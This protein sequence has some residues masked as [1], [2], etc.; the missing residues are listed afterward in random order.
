M[1]KTEVEITERDVFVRKGVGTVPSTTP[2]AAHQSCLKSCTG[3][4]GGCER[5]GEGRRIE[6]WEQHAELR[7]TVIIYSLKIVKR[8][9]RYL[10]IHFLSILQVS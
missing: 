2:S 1:G 3:S 4:G 9:N 6:Q 8:T 5:V 7:A 10:E